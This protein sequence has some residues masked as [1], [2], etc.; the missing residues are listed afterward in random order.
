MQA[1][2]VPMGVPSRSDFA[3]VPKLSL[4][5]MKV[6][7]ELGADLTQALAAIFPGVAPLQAIGK[8]IAAFKSTSDQASP[9]SVPIPPRSAPLSVETPPAAAAETQPGNSPKL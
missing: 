2:P 3:L 6:L 9:P 7:A 8:L 5:Q 1:L 4:D